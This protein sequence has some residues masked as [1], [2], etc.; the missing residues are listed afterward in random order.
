M[1]LEL[2][3]PISAFD[4]LWARAHKR[5]MRKDRTVRVPIEALKAVLIDH[6]VLRNAIKRAGILVVEVS[7]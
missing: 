7:E 3:T 1:T 4:D 2:N 6:T 5:N